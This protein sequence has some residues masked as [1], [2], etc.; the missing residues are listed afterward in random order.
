MACTPSIQMAVSQY[1]CCVTWPRTV[2]VGPFPRDVWTALLTSIVTGK[3]TKRGS[4][5]WA[6]SS[7]SE[8]TIFIV[9]RMLMTS[10][11]ELTWR[12]LRGTSHTPSTRHLRWQTRLIST[13]SLSENT[14]AQREIPSCFIGIVN[15]QEIHWCWM[16]CVFSLFW[17]ESI[18]NQKRYLNSVLSSPLIFFKLK[19][20]SPL[21]LKVIGIVEALGRMPIVL[22]TFTCSGKNIIDLM[23]FFWK[24]EHNLSTYWELIVL[25][26]KVV[27]FLEC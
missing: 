25:R 23:R 12:T 13:D 21:R 11:W 9:W 18:I 27:N 2:E 4:E 14:M 22:A 8:T 1:Q 19:V 17:A 7:G 16:C 26:Q 10:C 15:I 24:W 3:L 6:A 5:V 20:K